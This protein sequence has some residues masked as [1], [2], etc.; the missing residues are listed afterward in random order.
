MIT[1]NY[2]LVNET[3]TSN[4]LLGDEF[5]GLSSTIIDPITGV[6]YDRYEN[7]I[8]FFKGKFLFVFWFFFEN[9]WQLQD[10]PGNKQLLI[11]YNQSSLIENFHLPAIFRLLPFQNENETN[12]E[13]C[14]NFF[15]SKK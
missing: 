8:F 3:V 10:F 7:Q 5:F 11:D 9:S 2:T 6:F 12:Y 14:K 15:A 13:V 4:Q 1:I